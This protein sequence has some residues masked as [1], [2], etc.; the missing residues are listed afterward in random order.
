MPEVMGPDLRPVKRKRFEV[1]PRPAHLGGGWNLCLIGEYVDSGGELE[2][3]GGVFPADG[4]EAN[5]AAHA[6]ATE[7]GEDWL[8]AGE[9]DPAEVAE[10]ELADFDIGFQARIDDLPLDPAA[11]DAWRR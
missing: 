7:T 3:G 11:T 2:M 10:E 1:L 9:P 5:K 6:D 4:E 8:S